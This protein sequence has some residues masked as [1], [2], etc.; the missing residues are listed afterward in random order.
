MDPLTWGFI[1]T[2]IGAMVGASAS[3]ITTLINVQN[4]IKNQTNLEKY[5]RQEVFREF[6]RNNYLKI[7]EIF[8]SALRF[9]FKLHS[10]DV[11]NYY[12]NGE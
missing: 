4:S 8:P 11:K 5:K 10:I 1:G 12:K 3:I 7:Q 2:I 6:Q 9:A